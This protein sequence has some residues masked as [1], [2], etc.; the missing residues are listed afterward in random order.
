MADRDIEKLCSLVEKLT[1]EVSR[2]DRD[3]QSILKLTKGFI[4]GNPNV[5]GKLTIYSGDPLAVALAETTDCV[6][7]LRN[8]EYELSAMR[9]QIKS[10]AENVTSRDEFKRHLK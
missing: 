9:S 6:N 3:A 1:R 10:I 5:N 8:I 7:K 4:P 2:L